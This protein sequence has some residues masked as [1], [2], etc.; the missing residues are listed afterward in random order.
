M[1]QQWKLDGM[2]MEACT[3]EVGCPCIFLSAPSQ[4]DCKG[5]VAWHIDQGNYGDTALDGTNVALA[6]HSP[7]NMKDGNWRVALY[8]D[9]RASAEQKEALT[10][11]F[12]GQAGGHPALLGKHIGEV[13]GVSETD[14]DYKREGKRH[15]LRI[16]TAGSADIEAVPGQ[17]GSD[18]TIEG[19]PLA[20]GPG[21]PMVV[22]KSQKASYKDQGYDWTI[23]DRNG[24]YSRFS[25]QGP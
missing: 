15:S 12:G 24:F 21:F 14:I 4:G 22:A 23:S 8:L 17:D 19:H 11:I 6:L 2:Y 10:A 16:G 1:T 20:V 5:L 9:E 25:Y 7:G 3:C 18:V 13:M